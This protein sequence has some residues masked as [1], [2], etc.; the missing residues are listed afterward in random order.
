MIHVSELT[1]KY[2]TPQK[3]KNLFMDFF[4]RKYKEEIALKSISFDIKEGELIGFIGPN[5]AGKTTTMKVLAG[6]LYPTSGTVEVLGHTPFEKKYD[7]LRQIAFVMG[8]K[9]QLIW[10]LPAIDSFELNKKVYEIEEHTYKKRLHELTELLECES[11][12]HQ[13]VKTLSLGQRMRAEFI[14]SLLHQ[15]KVLFLDEPTIGL[16][17]FAQTKIIKF[18]RTYQKKYKSTIILTSHYMQDVQRLAE[19]IIMIDKGNLIFDGSLNTLRDTYSQKK[20]ITITLSKQLPHHKKLF[21]ELSYEYRY[22]QLTI[23]MKKDKLNTVLPDLLKKIEYMD[24][25]IENES[26]EEVIKRKF[27]E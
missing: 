17:I 10:D 16:D 13:P 21:T 1:K 24:L 20:T 27:E 15:P 22:P 25:S 2:R 18:I 6:I 7:Y 9:N 26:L 3:G 11:F 19:R 5:G 8:Q 12:I 14:S 23:H 4:A